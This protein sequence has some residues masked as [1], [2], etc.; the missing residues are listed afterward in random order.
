MF[1]ARHAM[2]TAQVAP[3]EVK[4]RYMTRMIFWQSG[5]AVIAI[6]KGKSEAE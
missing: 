5:G 2:L 3:L 4:P 1:C 6:F